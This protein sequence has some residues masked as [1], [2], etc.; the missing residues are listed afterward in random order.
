MSLRISAISSWRRK[1]P[2][3][4]QATCNYNW[5]SYFQVCEF[6]WNSFQSFSGPDTISFK[7]KI[8]SIRVKAHGDSDWCSSQDGVT[9]TALSPLREL[10][11]N[12]PVNICT[13]GIEDTE[14]S[15]MGSELRRETHEVSPV[16]ASAYCTEWVSRPQ[17]R[18]GAC[19][20]DQRILRAKG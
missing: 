3:L 7:C 15:V 20:W 4:W 12:A 19:R 16:V 9:G 14:R 6:Q 17:C 18:E 2:S 11:K 1:H 13:K 10:L 8:Y 5:K